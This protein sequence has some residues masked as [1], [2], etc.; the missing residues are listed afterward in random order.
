[1]SISVKEAAERLGVKRQR[2]HQLLQ[3]GALTGER[4][5][6]AGVIVWVVDEGSVEARKEEGRPEAA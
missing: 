5:D 1:M 6:I 4:K 2:I 3:S